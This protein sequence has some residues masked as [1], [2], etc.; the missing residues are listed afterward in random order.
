MR[1][2][3]D[4]FGDKPSETYAGH[5][6]RFSKENGLAGEDMPFFAND[7]F[8]S[9]SLPAVTG[10]WL[11]KKEMENGTEHLRRIH[12]L[13]KEAQ[14]RGFPPLLE[15]R[16]FGANT[17]DAQHPVWDGLSGHW[18]A[19]IGL[20]P[21]ALPE[22]ASGFLCRFADSASGRAITAFAHTELQR[23][24]TATHGFTVK[25]DGAEDWHW[26]SG[27]PYLLLSAPDLS[28]RTGTR[29]WHER[30]LLALTYAVHRPASGLT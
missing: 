19:L 6:Q 13:L 17:G 24:F 23:S 21:A 4:R 1:T 5:R 3:I 27:R 16:A 10:H 18:L 12:H 2:L 8:R 28:L 25:S 20:E 7:F 11:D 14:G 26:I 30:T 29:R 22:A 9:A 15:V